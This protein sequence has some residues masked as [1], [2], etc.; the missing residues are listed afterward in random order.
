MVESSG[1]G[2]LIK[3]DLSYIFA[4]PIPSRVKTATQEIIHLRGW[5]HPLTNILIKRW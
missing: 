3:L 4:A 2:K 1:D 5:K